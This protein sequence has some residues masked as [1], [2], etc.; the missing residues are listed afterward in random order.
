MV[1]FMA[2]VV[3]SFLW[4]SRRKQLH[5]RDASCVAKNIAKLRRGREVP[6]PAGFV[7]TPGAC[8]TWVKENPQSVMTLVFLHGGCYT[9]GITTFHWSMISWLAKALNARVVVPLYPLAPEFTATESL[10]AVLSIYEHLVVPSAGVGGI[11]IMGDSAGG[12]LGLALAQALLLRG[13]AM[14]QPDSLI[15]IAPWLDVALED[16]ALREL[17]KKDPMLSVDGLQYAGRLWAGVDRMDPLPPA[18]R[19][20]V[21]M[22][23]RSSSA[24]P[25][26][27]LALNDA[28]VSPLYG[29]VVGLPP[30]SIWTGTKDI[31]TPDCRRLRDRCASEAPSATCRYT[32]APGMIHVWPLFRKLGVPESTEALRQIVEAV[33]TDT[34]RRRPG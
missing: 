17:E 32:E 9:F 1:S 14:R 4:L 30:V 15:L 7:E 28:R 21:R 16:P 33:H 18:H 11:C 2:R 13:P 8:R 27:P 34:S 3:E 10:G 5:L 6:A 20:H 12:G 23:P 25:P 31:L 29:P 19:S 24:P 22:A 26:E